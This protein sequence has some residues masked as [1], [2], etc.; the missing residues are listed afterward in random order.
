MD[1]GFEYS[2]GRVYREFVAFC[3]SSEAI[4]THVVVVR[5][6]FE[7]YVEA[8]SRPV[9]SLR[10]LT[11]LLSKSRSVE[12]DGDCGSEMVFDRS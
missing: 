11:A 5:R 9:T 6:S 3:N 7:R 8:L 2:L 10:I 1:I 4:S 12:D